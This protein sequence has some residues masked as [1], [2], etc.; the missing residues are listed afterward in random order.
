M[1]NNALKDT[2]R[3]YVVVIENC[4]LNSKVVLIR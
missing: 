1:T 3:V 2:I 4:E